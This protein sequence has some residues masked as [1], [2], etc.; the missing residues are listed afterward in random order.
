MRS[1]SN[2]QSEASRDG[3]V[4]LRSEIDEDKVNS[5]FAA[6]SPRL[7]RTALRL[8]RSRED[9][10]DALQDALLS[11]FR[12]LDKF[13]GRS[14]V[15][16]WLTRIVV[17]SALMTMRRQRRHFTVPFEDPSIQDGF[18]QLEDVAATQ[19]ESP[20]EACARME[21]REIL[22][23][24]LCTIPA[25]YRLALQLCHVEG[26]KIQEA[27]QSLGLR[28]STFKSHLSRGRRMMKRQVNARFPL[29]FRGAELLLKTRAR[30]YK[31][32]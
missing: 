10:E 8:L 3:D 24:A 9:A 28:E 27:A 31:E 21:T 4:G 6:H 5:L 22:R 29:K 25:R 20:E 32:T 30:Q 16:T 12:N 1:N 14:Q 11:A 18:S 26:M 15:S 2:L 13:E 17:N 23:H 7:F 19:M